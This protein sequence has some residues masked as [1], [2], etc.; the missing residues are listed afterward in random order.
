MVD[1]AQGEAP[2]TVREMTHAVEESNRRAK[3]SA[4]QFDLPSLARNGCSTMCRLACDCKTISFELQAHHTGYDN[5]VALTPLYEPDVNTHIIG[6][7]LTGMIQE[8]GFNAVELR[9]GSRSTIDQHSE[10]LEE[11]SRQ[12]PSQDV[13]VVAPGGLVLKSQSFAPAAESL[14]VCVIEKIGDSTYYV[15]M[16]TAVSERPDACAVGP[17]RAR[18]EW[19]QPAGQEFS[20]V[21]FGVWFKTF[22]I[23]A[24]SSMACAVAMMGGNTVSI[25]D[26]KEMWMWDAIEAHRGK[27]A[28]G[29]GVAACYF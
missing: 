28:L 7:K 5:C 8:Y 22:P 26:P 19:L 12:Y 21:Q 3:G 23:T 29:S 6:Y 11:A 25:V 9:F 15:H 18:P 10:W 4:I 24:C 17:T 20:D 27:E 2:F 16:Y 13:N 1:I 14:V